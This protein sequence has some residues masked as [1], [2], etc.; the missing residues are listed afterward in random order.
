MRRGDHARRRRAANAAAIQRRSAMLLPALT[1]LVVAGCLSASGVAGRGLSDIA[2]EW[3]G[4]WSGPAGHSLAAVSIEPSGAY[5]ARM[6]LD[7]GDRDSQ[8]VII[9]LPS[10]R[11]RYQGGDGNGDVRLEFTGGATTMRFAPDGGGGGGTF[12]RAP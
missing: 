12:R 3:R 9:V 4:R 6:F 10:G 11:L 8:G 1:L 7:G 2:G 5:K